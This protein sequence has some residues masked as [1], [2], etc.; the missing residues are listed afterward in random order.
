MHHELKFKG[1]GD[2]LSVAKEN[3]SEYQF[4]NICRRRQFSQT[5]SYLAYESYGMILVADTEVGCVFPMVVVS[6]L[7]RAEFGRNDHREDAPHFRCGLNLKIQKDVTV[8]TFNSLLYDVI[9]E[10]KTDCLN[11]AYTVADCLRPWFV[12]S[13]PFWLQS[14]LPGLGIY[15]TKK[16]LSLLEIAQMNLLNQYWSSDRFVRRSQ[17][18]LP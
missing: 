17:S 14:G 15:R 10:N 5:V 8:K 13:K 12:F 18:G 11:P 3:C 16:E 9:C 1:V 6:I 2:F 4:Q 7:L